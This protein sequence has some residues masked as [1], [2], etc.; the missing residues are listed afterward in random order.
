MGAARWGIVLTVAV[1]ACGGIDSSDDPGADVDIGAQGAPPGTVDVLDYLIGDDDTWPRMGTQLQDQFVDDDR[2]EICWVKYG[3]ANMFECWRW[4]DDYVYHE[5]DRALDGDRPG[6]SYHFTDGRWLPRYLSGTWR[7]DM[8]NNRVNWWLADCTAVRG[9]EGQTIDD[10]PP[11]FPYLNRAW[12]EPAR[13]LGG[14]LGTREVLVLEYAPHLFGKAPRG[15]PEQFRFARGAGWFE[16]SRGASVARFDRR[17]G[18][19]LVPREPRVCGRSVPDVEGTTL[20]PGESL[21]PDESLRSPDGRSVVWYQAG[22]GNLV[23]YTD[24]EPVWSTET[25]GT[26]PGRATMQFDGNFV[27]HDA[28]GAVV[29]DAHT[30]DR[31]GARLMLRDGGEL[32]VDLDGQTLWSSQD[33]S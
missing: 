13:D 17:G 16:W 11:V 4:D 8:A 31:P 14:D 6:Q 10:G 19:R 2:Q 7:L 24:D 33:E 25:G 26:S 18:P 30:W 20:A 22:D 32:S 23:V 29:W 1:T 21:G 15:T 5:V 27:I 9:P 28:A 3:R 12:L